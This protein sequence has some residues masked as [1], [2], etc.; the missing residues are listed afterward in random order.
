MHVSNSLSVLGS[1]PGGVEQTLEVALQILSPSVSEK[2]GQRGSRDGRLPHA[3]RIDD[4][5]GR[6]GE[7]EDQEGAQDADPCLFSAFA[8]STATTEDE[9]CGLEPYDFL[10]AL[11]AAFAFL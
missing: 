6:F 1:A 3:P 7:G 2:E 8:V 4:L 9:C 11:A 5:A 10:L